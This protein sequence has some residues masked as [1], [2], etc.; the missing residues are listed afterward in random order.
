MLFQLILLFIMS[1]DIVIKKQIEGAA[2][3]VSDFSLANSLSSM[4]VTRAGK[5]KKYLE[6]KRDFY[7]AYVNVDFRPIVKNLMW[8]DFH[9]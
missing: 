4:D 9:T 2:L 1:F 6:I 7:R 5:W 3:N 8:S